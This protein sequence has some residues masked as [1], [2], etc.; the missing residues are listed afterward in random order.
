[1]QPLRP[2][3]RPPVQPKNGKSD[4]EVS[5]LALSRPPVWIV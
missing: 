4:L 3:W 2:V 1:L 5:L